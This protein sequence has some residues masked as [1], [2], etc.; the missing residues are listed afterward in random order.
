[1]FADPKRSVVDIVQ[2]VGRALRPSP[3]KNFACVVVPVLINSDE[4]SDQAMPMRTFETVVTTLRALASNDGRIIEYL[5]NVT[6]G[7]SVSR[8]ISPIDIVL[9]PGIEIDVD[10]FVEAVELRLFTRLAKLSW[11]PFEMAR[12]FAR[13]LELDNFS[14]WNQYLAEQMPQLPQ[15]PPDIPTNPNMVY[16]E[17]GW[18][19]W[20][21][22]LGT[23]RVATSRR[24]FLPFGA[25][26]D[27][28]RSLGLSSQNEWSLYCQGKLKGMKARPE[29]IPT[30][31]HRTYKDCGWISYGDWLGTGS[32]HTSEWEFLP[33][34]E[35]RKFVRSQ[36]MKS[37]SDFKRWVKSA[38]PRGIPSNPQ[39]TYK[40][41]GWAGW[42]DFLG[43]N[44]VAPHL[45]E[46][47]SFD[48][49]R[50]YAH[51]LNLKSRDEW[52]AFCK[53]D[54]PEKG[55]LPDDIPAY[56]ARVYERQGWKGVGDWLGT[57]T[58][59]PRLREY[60]EFNEARTFVRAL[61]LRTRDDWNTFCRGDGNLPADI[62]KTP[63]VVYK[64]T[65]WKNLKDWLGVDADSGSS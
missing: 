27:F 52:I 65:G 31:P 33:F 32:I 37:S 34:S 46:Y 50:S 51:S 24:Q 55:E 3:G 28:A 25:A 14:Q 58:V 18:S 49:A 64:T 60:R 29:D 63:W 6:S 42:D 61:G 40:D 23:G 53:G 12:E 10:S 62:P 48:K 16:K 4:L 2:A 17:Q 7:E 22:W 8:E 19:S 57:G 15:R 5:R 38:R 43:T 11:R 44:T 47:R 26:R 39:R 45:R 41:K 20:G 35:A 9:P 30:N 59:A 21:D 36:G 1:L 13:S 54:I 56:P